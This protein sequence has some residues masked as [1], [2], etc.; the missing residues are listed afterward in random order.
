MEMG[1]RFALVHTV[2]A[3]EA[4]TD[5]RST[6]RGPGDHT[7]LETT[8][9]DRAGGRI[10]FTSRMG[11]AAYRALLADVA[12]LAAA[13]RHSG[14]TRRL[15]EEAAAPVQRRRALD[16]GLLLAIALLA[17]WAA[18]LPWIFARY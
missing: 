4:I 8:V 9:T 1:A 15:I 16:P 17:G 11:L 18:A 7:A 2:M 3:W 13:S 14:L 6:W 10:R 12:G 5:I